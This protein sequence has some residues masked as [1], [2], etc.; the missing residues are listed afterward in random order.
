[1]GHR[2]AGGR[3]PSRSPRDFLLETGPHMTPSVHGPHEHPSRAGL[4]PSC[5]RSGSLWVRQHD[6]VRAQWTLLTPHPHQG[7]TSAPPGLPS[8]ASCVGTRG[9]GAALSLL[10]DEETGPR[11]MPANPS[12]QSL[13]SSS[14]RPLT[15]SPVSMSVLKLHV[16]ALSRVPRRRHTQRPHLPPLLLKC[17]T[18]SGSCRRTPRIL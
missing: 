7:P 8:P 13:V 1:M 4:C 2:A 3:G 12:D 5:G 18:T 6:Q 17:N 14:A 16:R 10:T 15:V 11:G 9:L